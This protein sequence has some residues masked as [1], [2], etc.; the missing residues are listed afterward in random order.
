MSAASINLRILPRRMLSKAE[1]SEYV[2][3]SSR[4]FD[5]AVSVRPLKMPDNSLRWDMHDLDV[6][7]DHLKSGV[8]GSDDDIVARL[9]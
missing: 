8:V 1:A 6:W 2:G 4:K 7:I 9:G 5:G 3:I